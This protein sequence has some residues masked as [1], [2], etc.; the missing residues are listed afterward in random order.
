MLASE[1]QALQH[2]WLDR[3]VAVRDGVPTLTRFRGRKGVVKSVNWNGHC[4]VEWHAGQ[5]VG[6]YDIE[7]ANLVRADESA[8]D[9]ED[10]K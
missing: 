1:I 2:E 9:T 8:T 7:P 5:D 6:W 10:L 3:V 4:L